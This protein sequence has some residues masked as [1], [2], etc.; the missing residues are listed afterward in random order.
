MTKVENETKTDEKR[1]SYKHAKITCIQWFPI[2]FKQNK[3]F[4]VIS[5]AILTSQVGIDIDIV[6][7]LPLCLIRN[8][9]RS[10]FTY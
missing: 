8:F 9:K 4:H 2:C 6:C 3:V 10:Y 7:H 5:M 1:R